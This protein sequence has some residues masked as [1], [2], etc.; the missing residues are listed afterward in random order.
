MHPCAAAPCKKQIEDRQAMCLRHWRMVPKIIQRR[1]WA[2][3][4]PGQTAAT[5]SDDYME[6]LDAGIAAVREREGRRPMVKRDEPLTGIYFDEVTYQRMAADLVCRR[7]A[8]MEAPQREKDRFENEEMVFMR[9]CTENQAQRY[10][11]LVQ[12]HDENQMIES[13]E[14]DDTEDEPL[15]S[16]VN[17]M[18]DSDPR[19]YPGEPE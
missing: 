19:A 7:D 3:Y 17:D 6:A 11:A 2:L 5:A 4:K 18:S 12:L 14:L 9:H 16:T 8:A 15:P 10:I 1:I 13:G